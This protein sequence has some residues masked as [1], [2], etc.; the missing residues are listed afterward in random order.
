[1]TAMGLDRKL[2]PGRARQFYQA[3]A[4]YRELMDLSE[5]LLRQTAIDALAESPPPVNTRMS[6][7]PR[8]R[9]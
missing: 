6:G 1:M 3:Y 8:A 2:D 7:A 9:A 4:D 5:Q